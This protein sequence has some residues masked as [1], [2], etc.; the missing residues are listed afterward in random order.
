MS[1]HTKF[2]CYTMNNWLFYNW[3]RNLYY[4]QSFR[5]KLNRWSFSPLHSLLFH[6]F[7]VFLIN[8]SFAVYTGWTLKLLRLFSQL[9]SS[10]KQTITFI[11]TYARTK[12]ED[13]EGKRERWTKFMKIQKDKFEQLH[14]HTHNNLIRPLLPIVIIIVFF[15]SCID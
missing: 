10:V 13:K 1:L 14:S 8:S 9:T 5:S 11:Q 4:I 6:F 7:L 3:I 15:S 2:F 12:K